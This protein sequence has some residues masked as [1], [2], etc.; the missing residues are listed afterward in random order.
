MSE[1]M[2]I[3]GRCRAS[4]FFYRSSCNGAAADCSADCGACS[5]CSPFASAVGSRYGSAR[6]WSRLYRP[7]Q[8]SSRAL[9][10]CTF[11]TDYTASTFY[12]CECIECRTSIR[13]EP[14]AACLEDKQN[15]QKSFIIDCVGK[16][17]RQLTSLAQHKLQLA[18]NPA[19]AWKNC[20][21]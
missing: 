11:A 17:R 7:H 15:K 2:S 1:L 19:L 21:K 9:C 5:S 13:R 4:S 10:S 6:C 12:P 18:M 3:W 14:A 20:R 8:S 16:L